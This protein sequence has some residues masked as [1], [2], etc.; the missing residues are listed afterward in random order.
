MFFSFHLELSIQVANVCSSTIQN[1]GA[2]ERLYHCFN[3]LG[4]G[5]VWGEEMPAQGCTVPGNGVGKRLYQL[6]GWEMHPQLWDTKQPQESNTS[7][8]HDLNAVASCHC[9]DLRAGSGGTIPRVVPIAGS[10]LQSLVA[11]HCS[12]RHVTSVLASH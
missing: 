2:V 10:P 4:I 3:S 1:R 5:K 7:W 6:R 12:C 11:S 9:A 8:T